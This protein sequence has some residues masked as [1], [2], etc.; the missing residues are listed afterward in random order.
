MDK[1][2]TGSVKDIVSYVAGT[3]ARET[4]VDAKTGA[5][6]RI[7]IDGVEDDPISG[8]PEPFYIE[9]GDNLYDAYN[10]QEARMILA[11]IRRGE[12]YPD[13][14]SSIPKRKPTPKKR[15]PAKRLSKRSSGN[16]MGLK[17][18]R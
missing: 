14:P 1:V 5:K 15:K 3:D 6:I 8:E 2:F 11:N 10:R 17:A 18:R 4:V 12:P 13:M 16:F 7:N 9:Y